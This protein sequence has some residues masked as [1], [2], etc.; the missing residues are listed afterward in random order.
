MKLHRT[1]VQ[2][3]I[4]TLQQIFE[5]GVYA[6]KAVEQVLKLNSKWG[7]RDR[8]FI[9]ETTYEM[10]RWW[11]LIEVSADVKENKTIDDYWKLLAAWLIIKEI[12]LPEWVEFARIDK[13]KIM[14]NYHQALKIRKYKESIPD[15]LDELGSNELGDEIW[16]TELAELNKEAQVVLRVNTLK[17]NII[18]LQRLLAEKE[19]E[20]E[21]I[22]DYN[23]ALV[24][25]K[26][27][28]LNQQ[29]EYKDGLFEI[30]SQP[31]TRPIKPLPR[32]KPPFFELPSKRPRR[33]AFRVRSIRG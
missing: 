2:A 11:R 16:T 24:L 25:K 26:R 6:D 8:R 13:D 22:G 12:E 15:W 1:L 17:T 20:V 5:E 27:Q 3:T 28:N 23:D 31:I 9:A 33:F 4:N 14:T 21:V 18:Q 7:S 29:G 30:F 10:V 19:I 32:E